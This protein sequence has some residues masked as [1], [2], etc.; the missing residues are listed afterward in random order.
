M[1]CP[2]C[3][4][5]PRKLGNIHRLFA[6]IHCHYFIIYQCQL[7]EIFPLCVDW[8][9]RN[10]KGLNWT[11]TVRT[12]VISVF[13]CWLSGSVGIESLSGYHRLCGWVG[14]R[15]GSHSWAI[16]LNASFYLIFNMWNYW[17]SIKQCK[18]HTHARRWRWRRL[19]RLAATA[20]AIAIC[21]CRCLC[22]CRVRCGQYQ[23]SNINIYAAIMQ[24]KFKSKPRCRCRSL[25]R[26]FVHLTMTKWRW[27]LHSAE[28]VAT[29]TTTTSTA[30]SL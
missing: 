22:L 21:S 20:A 8:C 13:D 2:R 4:L 30:T 3:F 16:W 11:A 19:T 27:H 25:D 14:S 9:L 29:K 26:A 6:Y 15:S 24:I 17:Q 23:N 12:S 10:A 28:V 18:R 1:H 5:C 7:V